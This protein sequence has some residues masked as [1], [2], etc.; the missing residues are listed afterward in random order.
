MGF[1]IDVLSTFIIISLT[2]LNLIHD[3]VPKTKDENSGEFFTVSKYITEFNDK[4]RDIL[5]FSHV[6]TIH[7]IV[8]G[9]VTE[10]HRS[11]SI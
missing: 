8:D 6:L 3:L 4:I 1:N 5:Y 2:L 10:N 7:P 11:Q 9:R